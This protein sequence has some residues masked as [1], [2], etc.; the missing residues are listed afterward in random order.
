MTPEVKDLFVSNLA[1][2]NAKLGTKW[3]TLTVDSAEIQVVNGTNTK[4]YVTGEDK[5]K[6]LVVIHKPYGDGKAEVIQASF[7][8]D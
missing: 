8:V 3:T 5:S 2:I 7:I 6:A 4:G 1:G